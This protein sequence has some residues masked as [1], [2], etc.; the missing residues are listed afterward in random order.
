MGC[1]GGGA[2]SGGP[3][4]GMPAMGGMAPVAAMAVPCGGGA[5]ACFKCEGKGFCH[6][7]AMDHDKSPYERCFFC[8]DCDG[9]GGRGNIQGGPAMGMPA[10]A[11]MGM[12]AM[13]VPAMGGMAPV[14]AMAVPCGGGAQACFKCEGKGFCHT[15]AMDHDRGPDERCF[16]C[17][18]CDGCR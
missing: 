5:Q 12:P 2:I 4:M 17:Q 16:F 15:S 1:G 9:C 10:M 18:D 11:G 8:Q 6:M 7:S 3:A 14:A 13:G